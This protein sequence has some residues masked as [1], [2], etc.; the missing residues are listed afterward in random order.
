MKNHN[1]GVALFMTLMLLF[2]LSLIVAAILITTYNYNN[3]C[4]EQAKRT[5]AMTLAEAGIHYAFWQLRTNPAFAT[6]TNLDI[7]GTNVVIKI[8]GPV[9]G[10]YTISSK[11]TY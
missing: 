6:D 11:V 5:K 9:L 10:R 7:N 1:K 3:I 2:L 4:E 8:T